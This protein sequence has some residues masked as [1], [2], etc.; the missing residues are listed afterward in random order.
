METVGRKL[1]RKFSGITN[2]LEKKMKAGRYYNNQRYY[3]GNFLFLDE[4]KTKIDEEEA[5]RK[6]TEESALLFGLI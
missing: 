4:L 3:L 5:M 1:S 2:I 6:K